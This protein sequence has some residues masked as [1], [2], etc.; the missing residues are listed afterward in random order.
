MSLISRERGKVKEDAATQ[1]QVEVT[2][3]V[4]NIDDAVTQGIMCCFHKRFLMLII[5][6]VNIYYIDLE[7]GEAT[8]SGPR[9]DDTVTQDE[10][11]IYNKLNSKMQKVFLESITKAREEGIR[12]GIEKERKKG[13]FFTNVLLVFSAI[14]AAVIFDV[15]NAFYKNED[16][17]QI[18]VFILNALIYG[19]QMVWSAILTVR[20]SP[21]NC[22]RNYYVSTFVPLLLG[23]LLPAILIFVY[24]TN[25]CPRMGRGWCIMFKSFKRFF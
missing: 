22:T 15:L 5:A 21:R 25:R 8:T 10:R 13:K 18:F 4:P 20:E 11:E 17:V 12:E 3:S 2:K 6:V 14:F 7:R 16:A 1:E 24:Y 9:I 19:L 23:I